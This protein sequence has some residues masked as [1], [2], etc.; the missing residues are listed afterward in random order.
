MG[1]VELIE[2]RTETSRRVVEVNGTLEGFLNGARE[3]GHQ[4]LKLHG[5][6][7]WLIIDPG[8]MAWCEAGRPPVGNAQSEEPQDPGEVAGRAA[9]G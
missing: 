3:Y 6:E 7:R 8:T 4:V 9:P 5:L 2:L 1:A